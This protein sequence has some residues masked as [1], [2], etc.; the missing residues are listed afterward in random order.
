MK[1]GFEKWLCKKTGIGEYYIDPVNKL[2]ILPLLIKAMWAIN[3][4]GKYH[5]II[6]SEEIKVTVRNTWD[7]DECGYFRYED[8]PEQQALEKALGYI[9]EQEYEC[10]I[11]RKNPII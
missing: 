7:D 6:N 9:Y 3:R 2:D 10:V 1:E 4:E 5:I 11:N 8:Y